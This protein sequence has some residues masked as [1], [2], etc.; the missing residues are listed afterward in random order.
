MKPHVFYLPPGVDFAAEFVRGFDARLAGQPPEAA[1][2]A[3]IWANT[4]R[5]ARRLRAAFETGPARLIPRLRLLTDISLPELPAPVPPLRRRLELAQLVAALIAREPDLA[6]RE[7]AFALADS[8]AALLDEMQGEGVGADA[9]AALDVS[10]QSGHWARALKFLAIADAYTAHDRPD[11]E[12]LRRR[13]VLA[14]AERWKQAPPAHPVIV[15]GST[16]S[17]GTTALF[18]AA[19]ARL[20]QGAVILPGFESATPWDDLA[21]ANTGEDH[22]QFRFRRLADLLGIDPAEIPAWT[23]TP[24]ARPDRNALISLALRPAPVTDRWISDGPSLGPLSHACKGM[25]L[26]EAPS[27]RAEA[28]AIALRLRQAVTD[29]VEAALI[30][31]DRMLTRQVTAALDR[32]DLRPDDSAGMPLALSPPGRF[33]RQVADLVAGPVTAAGFIALLKHPL[34]HSGAGRGGHLLQVQQYEL[35]LRQEGSGF[36]AGKTH[37]PVVVKSWRDWLF[38]ILDEVQR[39][40]SE[41]LADHVAR[42]LELAERIA[43]GSEAS[44]SGT[45]WDEAAGREARAQMDE[46]ARHADA[47]GT[48]SA[49]DYARLFAD[50][51]AK[52]EVRE[53][54]T[55]HPLVRILGPREARE[56]AAPLVIL[57]GLNEGTWPALPAPDPWLNRQM[58]LQAG[59]LLPERQVGL[60]A[61][62]FQQGVA[63]REVWLSRAIRSDE[64]ETVP[65]RWLARLTNLLSGLPGQGGR[66]AL[67]A[68]RAEGARWIAGAEALSIPPATIPPEPRPAPAPPLASR[69]KRL[70]VTTVERLL[71]DPYSVYA[72]HVLRLRKLDPLTP[73]ADPQLRGTIL[74]SVFEDLFRDGFDPSAPDAAARL[75][76]TAAR[77]LERECPWP[78]VRRVWLA[79]LARVAQWF[80]EGEGARQRLAAPHL[81][82]QGGE[83]PVADTGVTLTVKADRIDLDADGAALIYDYKTGKPPTVKQQGV[84]DKQLLLTAALVES[85]GI[86]ALGPVPVRAAEFIGLGSKPE[87]VPAPL[88]DHPPAQVRAELLRLLQAWADPARGYT[89]RMAMMSERRESDYDH[90]SRFGEWD[91]SSAP[92]VQ[93]LP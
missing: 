70:S 13:A 50:I 26:L 68:M 21:D 93:V 20:P 42:H 35:Q 16:G 29:G 73:G 38:V 60:A 43:A 63:A 80:V 58:R 18:M 65:S 1:A 27:P 10:D 28:E 19:V 7:D 87:I 88:T 6:A 41:P 46:L 76:A 4:P 45:L 36:P 78:F 14:L 11:P 40:G 69:P 5:M 37:L 3:E 82:E 72:S 24:P 86:A 55:G 25:V 31:P 17:R 91:L 92:V 44:G 9:I 81:F 67:A 61:H 34:S 56:C 15:A 85:G 79:R 47:G 51:F 8:L 83:L 62:D 64:A 77:V 33:L 22:P 48:M 30:S 89:A 59:L 90:L 12:G 75:I 57:A 52:G 2:R 71:R 54:D 84:F 74:H 49:G 39:A 53:R 66:E 23:A 32:W